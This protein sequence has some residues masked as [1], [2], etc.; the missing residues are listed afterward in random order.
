MKKLYYWFKHV[1]V[2]KD[3]NCKRFCPKCPYWDKCNNDNVYIDY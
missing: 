2:K 3:V 1:I